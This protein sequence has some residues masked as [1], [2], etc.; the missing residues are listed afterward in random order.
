MSEAQTPGARAPFGKTALVLW[1]LS[2]IG[3]LLI[4]PYVATLE[5]KALAAAVARTHLSLTALLALST[6]QTA[7]L[8]AIAVSIGLLASRRLGLSTPLIDAWLLKS[9]APKYTPFTLL[10]AVALGVATGAL[11]ITLDRALFAPLPSVAAFIK[12]A[13]TGASHPAPSQGFLASFYGALDEEIL[14]RLGLLSLIALFLRTLARLLGA[15]RDNPL[16]S[17][18]FWTANILTAVLFGLGHLP[19]TAAIAPLSAGLVVRAIVLN[20]TAGI[21]YGWLFRRFGLE[22]AMLSHF[23]T[24]IVLHVL[25]A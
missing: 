19:A 20:G 4:L 9:S 13:T 14:M 5:S 17:G 3:A 16:P 23:S 2:L 6:A 18:V 11:L 24:D 10:L 8:L 22:W 25:G 7:V 15:S 1:A 21:V 12:S